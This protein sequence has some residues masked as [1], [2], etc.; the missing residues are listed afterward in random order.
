ML[1]NKLKIIIITIIIII[2]GGL[3]YTLLKEK[4]TVIEKEEIVAIEPIVEAKEVIKYLTVDIKGAITKPGVYTI[5][6]G[7]RVNDVIKKAGGLTKYANTYYINLSKKV[8]DE[9]VIIIY[10]KSE[11]TNYQKKINN[12]ITTTKK[13]QENNNNDAL[14]PIPN[15]ISEPTSNIININSATLDQ[16]MTLSGIGETKAQDIIIYRNQNNGFKSIDEIKNVKGIGDSTFAKIKDYIT[17]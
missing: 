2:N 17:I 15:T 9:M 14:V 13:L 4:K 6:E 1:I 7:S 3:Y 11:V 10:T 12:D 8:F 5:E 16:L